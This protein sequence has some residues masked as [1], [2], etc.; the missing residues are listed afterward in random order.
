MAPAD[1]H[2]P[3]V[4]SMAGM[5]DSP[6]PAVLEE[7]MAFLTGEEAAAIFSR[8]GFTLLVREEKQHEIAGR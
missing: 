2:K 3:I 5:S 8:C 7:F 6:H 4:F 1:S